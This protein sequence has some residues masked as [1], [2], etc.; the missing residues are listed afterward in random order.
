MIAETAAAIRRGELRARELVESC[1][2]R[3]AS[4]DALLG[5]F[6]TLD[7]QR[8]LERAGHIDEDLVRARQHGGRAAGGIGGL[9]A[10]GGA[11]GA[12]GGNQAGDRLLLGIP[13]ACKD[14]ICTR[15]VPTTCASRILEGYVP[16][17][18]ATVVEGLEAA[19]AVLLGKTNMDEFAMGSSGEN[20][21]F[22]PTRNPRDT[23]RVP[24]GS[25]SGSAAAVAAGL[26]PFALGSDTGGSV[27]QP[28][29]FCGVVGLKP[30]YGRVSRYGLVAFASSLDQIGPL[31]ATVEDCALVMEVLAGHD[32][33]DATSADVPVPA[34]REVLGREVR[35]MKLGVPRE[36]MGEGIEPGVREAVEA[37]LRVFEDLGCVVEE[38]SLPHTEYALAVYYLVAPAEASS[39]LARYDGV[40][41]G[42]RVEEGDI[43]GMYSHTRRQGF[44]AEV[45]RRIMLGTYALSAGYYDAYYLKAQKVR[46]L[47]KRD[48]EQAFSRY[49][50]L[51]A[52][53]SPTVAFRLGERTEDPL[54][55]YM[56]DVCTIP[57]NLAGIP[58]ISIP[59]GEEA[60]LPVGLQ[61]MGP[62]FAE[63]TILQAA[64]AFERATAGASWRRQGGEG[65]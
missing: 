23:T 33:R 59:C 47:V 26:V 65:R 2:S 21:A 55:M 7:G 27:R 64:Y 9:Q 24:G 1:L 14:N 25:S 45:R 11:P 57:V 6:L 5:C 50:L 3:I 58:A 12:A 39:N 22:F 62:P 32:P 18:S 13:Y 53:T 8:A 34:Y 17:Y 42:L 31:T 4:L 56:A 43:T 63:S 51:V 60:G 20:S 44:G 61:I 48:F 16:P 19:G 15:G 54:S 35:G 28:A 41:Y 36:Y 46:T 29:S 49:D 52:P 30:T 40:R 10:R 37:A 38:C